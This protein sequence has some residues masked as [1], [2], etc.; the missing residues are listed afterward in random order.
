MNTSLPPR[1][2]ALLAAL[3]ALAAC[4]DDAPAK[5]AVPVPSGRDVLPLDV[6]TNAPGTAGAAARFRF[7][8]PD[9]AAD[10]LEASAA[11][12][13]ALC[14]SHALPFTVGMVPA[15]QQIIITLMAVEVPFGEP[16]PDVVQ[17]FETYGI[18]DGLCVVEPF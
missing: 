2:A 9:L 5:G 7:M 4:Q 8:V 12:M 14:D 1:L 6:I 16:A 18:E 13:Q 11:D 17:F 3:S 15:P 10:D